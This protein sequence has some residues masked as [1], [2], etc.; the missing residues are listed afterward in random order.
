M[1]SKLI[2]KVIAMVLII[3]A[4]AELP[5]IAWAVWFGETGMIVY[6]AVPQIVSLVIAGILLILSRN[7]KQHNLSIKDGF[8]T[9]TVLWLV[10]TISGSMPYYLSGVIPSYTDAFF[11]TMSGFTACGATILEYAS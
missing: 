9:V 11:E 1:N 4:M 7:R 8:I 5:S 6:F 2:L 10:A 3:I